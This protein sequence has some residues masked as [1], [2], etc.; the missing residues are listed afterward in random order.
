MIAVIVLG[1]SLAAFAIVRLVGYS[2]ATALTVSA[3]LAQIG[4]FSFMVAALGKAHGLLSAEGQNLILAGAIISITL[5]PAAFRI[6]LACRR[7]LDRAQ[8]A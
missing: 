7:R 2:A 8:P 5:N 1:K 3:S 6:A 4:E